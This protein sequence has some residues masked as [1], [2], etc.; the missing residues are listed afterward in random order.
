MSVYWSFE[1]DA[2]A[3]RC[4]YLKELMGTCSYSEV[5][6]AIS[7]FQERY[8]PTRSWQDIPY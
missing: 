7:R 2:V 5:E 6:R 3:K 1:L 8:P 4:L